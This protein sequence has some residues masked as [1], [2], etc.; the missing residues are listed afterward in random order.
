MR[1]SHP[2]LVSGGCHPT[3]ASDNHKPTVVNSTGIPVRRSGASPHGG[4]SVRSG[5]WPDRKSVV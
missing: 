5:A 4:R 3:A 2:H 1:T